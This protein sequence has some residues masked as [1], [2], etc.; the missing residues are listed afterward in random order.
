VL[1]YVIE[2][3]KEGAKEFL[4]SLLPPE[5]QPVL[6]TEGQKKPEIIPFP[7]NQER[8][9]THP[10]I[11]NKPSPM[12]ASVSQRERMD[13]MQSQVRINE[14]LRELINCQSQVK[15]A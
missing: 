6:S 15:Q 5:I 14:I 3:M 12:A 7:V 1:D 13:R 10:N 8:A 4:K 2:P 9:T 11:E